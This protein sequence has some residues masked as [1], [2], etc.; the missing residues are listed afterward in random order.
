[1]NTRKAA[2]ILSLL[3][4]L[5]VVALACAASEA[6]ARLAVL[7]LLTGEGLKPD[8]GQTLA[9]FIRA[10]IVQTGRFDVMDRQDIRRVLDEQ[11]F[12]EALSSDTQGLVKAGKILAVKEIMGG[13]VAKLGRVWV[14]VLNLV[15]V[16]SARLLNSQ[17]IPY[18]G[19]IEGLLECTTAVALKLLGLKDA[20]PAVSP[21]QP[22]APSLTRAPIET[23]GGN[24]VTV[25]G[26]VKLREGFYGKPGSHQLMS[27]H[28]VDAKLEAWLN[29]SAVDLKRFE[30]KRARLSG[31]V[32][33]KPGWSQP[34][35]TV[36]HAEVESRDSDTVTL[37]G[38]LRRR[39]GFYGKPGSHQLMSSDDEGA[40][41]VAWLKSSV[42]E[43]KPFENKHVRISGTATR[44][45]G[46][47]EP[48]I[49]VIRA[50]RLR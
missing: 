15:E 11:K 38:W 31:T 40:K 17:A 7:D 43:M 35:V 27:S 47:N 41:P 50:E 1:M 4:L 23:S 48:L 20:A 49:T 46:W 30:G 42:V 14:V 8:D 22:P 18:D 29:S 34:L 2:R 13:R 44:K 12:Q 36:V 37:E 25:E 33:W 24:A 28:D 5:H 21:A 26:W 6:K 32:S 16:G 3:A 19:P 9:M 39:Q 10:A 45:P